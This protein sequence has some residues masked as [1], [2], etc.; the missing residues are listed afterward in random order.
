MCGVNKKESDSILISLPRAERFASSKL[1]SAQETINVC[2]FLGCVVGREHLCSPKRNAGPAMISHSG[3][4]PQSVQAECL[5]LPPNQFCW[6]VLT[7]YRRDS[8]F[9]F[10]V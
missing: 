10:G 5:Q 7:S 6:F 3:V 9:A 1:C 4:V 2:F 8:H